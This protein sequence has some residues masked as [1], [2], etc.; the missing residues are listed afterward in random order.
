[1][2]KGALRALYSVFTDHPNVGIAV[3]KFLQADASILDAG[4]IIFTDASGWQYAVP[5]SRRRA[6][7]SIA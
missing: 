1:M 6:A 7:S 5:E 3:P 2:L 4:G